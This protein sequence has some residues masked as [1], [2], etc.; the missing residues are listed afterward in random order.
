[1]IGQ[2]RGTPYYNTITYQIERFEGQRAC[3]TGEAKAQQAEEILTHLK[4]L[5]L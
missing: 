3:N 1:M 4:I 5:Q 2:N